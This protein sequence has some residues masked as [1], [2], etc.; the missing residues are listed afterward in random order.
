MFEMMKLVSATCSA[1][2]QRCRRN[3]GAADETIG[4]IF[5]REVECN[6]L[7]IE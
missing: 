3:T 7:G 5:E 4:P 6:T 2:G 1:V